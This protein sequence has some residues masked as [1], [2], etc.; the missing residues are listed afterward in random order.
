M[1]DDNT[2]NSIKVKETKSS[3]DGK[4]EV[5]W[6]SEDTFTVTIGANRYY[7]ISVDGIGYNLNYSQE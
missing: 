1:D 2:K 7:E 5:E 6:I 3:W 4:F